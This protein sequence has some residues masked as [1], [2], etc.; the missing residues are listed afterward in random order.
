MKGAEDLFSVFSLLLPGRCP[1]C[2]KGLRF[3]QKECDS[4]RNDLPSKTVNMTLPCGGICISPFV[5]E[6]LARKA[7]LEMKYYGHTFNARS[8]AERIAF[9]VCEAS[10]SEQ[11]DIIT[12]VPMHREQEK[13]RGFN[14]SELLAREVS[15][16]LKKPYRTLLLKTEKTKQQ[17]KLSRK[18]R[19]YNLSGVYKAVNTKSIV[20]K[21]I[22]LIDDICTTGSTM[23]ECSRVLRE[24]GAKS[25]LCA[26]AAIT[27]PN[28][29]EQTLE[30]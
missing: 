3:M 15:R 30:S 21:R 2:R 7:I 19:I 11:T 4:C 6:S 27:T 22:L 14:Q 13:E 1:Y 26:A 23:S 12:A 28:R 10:M 9:A 16:L 17:H 29:T 5:Y 24:A 18:I 8:L 25:V 20:G